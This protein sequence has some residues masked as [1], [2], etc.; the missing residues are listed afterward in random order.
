MKL[1]NL[2]PDSIVLHIYGASFSEGWPKR[3]T[4]P[5][6]GYIAKTD[7]EHYVRLCDRC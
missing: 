2:T 7:G 1:E 6:S 3:I 5:P 4:I